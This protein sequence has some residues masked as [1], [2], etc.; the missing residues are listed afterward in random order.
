MDKYISVDIPRYISAVEKLVGK[1]EAKNRQSQKYKND[2]NTLKT[3]WERNKPEFQGNAN[4]R[5]AVALSNS[6]N[7]NYEGSFIRDDVPAME[8]YDQEKFVNDRSEKIKQIHE[9]AK[10]VRN[11]AGV[12]NEKI[13]DQGDKLDSINKQMGKQVE[14]VKVANKELVATREITSKRN[15]C[16][17]WMVLFAIMISIILGVSIYFMFFHNKP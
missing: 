2:F 9:D 16:M 15:K 3:K 4:T 14:D 7:S 12:I 5:Y 8:V 1:D 13:Y 17:G 6:I 10:E 11:L